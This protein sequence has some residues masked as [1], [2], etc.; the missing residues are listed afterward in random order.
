MGKGQACQGGWELLLMLWLGSGSPVPI[1]HWLPSLYTFLSPLS[2]PESP[3]QPG[4]SSPGV[5][6]LRLL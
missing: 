4:Y 6:S 2:V 5:L 3:S 1:M